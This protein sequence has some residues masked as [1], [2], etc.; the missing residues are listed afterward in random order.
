MNCSFSIAPWKLLAQDW[1]LSLDRLGSDGDWRGIS[2]QSPIFRLGLAGA[3][4][5]LGHL[6]PGVGEMRE[7]LQYWESMKCSLLSRIPLRQKDVQ[8][9]GMRNISEE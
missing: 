6:L 2:I 8:L 1:Q 4:Q 3:L 7:E 9:A 5:I